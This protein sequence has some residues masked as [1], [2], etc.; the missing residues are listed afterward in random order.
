[1]D[2]KLL[3]T[4]EG[5]KTLKTNYQRLIDET[6]LMNSNDIVDEHVSCRVQSISI[7]S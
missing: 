4:T 5:S 3:N 2:R 6:L 7:A 1:M